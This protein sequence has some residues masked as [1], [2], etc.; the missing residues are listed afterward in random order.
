[1]NTEIP[2][3]NRL[4]HSGY[5]L[6]LLKRDGD[7]ALFAKG[8]PSHFHEHYETVIVRHLPEKTIFDKVC[9]A[10]ESLPLNED[11]GTAGWT[12]VDLEKAEKRFSALVADRQEAVLRGTSPPV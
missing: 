3:P 11:W 1:M 6:R 5:T 7:I 8:K 10:K 12:D 4:T 2:L 9:Q